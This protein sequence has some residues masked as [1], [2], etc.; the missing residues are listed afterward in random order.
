M[1]IVILR[2]C[3]KILMLNEIEATYFV[4]LVDKIGW[5]FR[6]N[7]RLSNLIMDKFETAVKEFEPQELITYLD[8]NL[9]NFSR[10]LAKKY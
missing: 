8:E 5:E 9:R 10:S 7:D 4:A 6:E 2:L 3:A 1:P